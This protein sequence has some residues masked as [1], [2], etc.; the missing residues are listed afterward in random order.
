MANERMTAAEIASADRAG[1]TR[2][3]CA[4][5]SLANLLTAASWVVK[6]FGTDDPVGQTE[7]REEIGKLRIALRAYRFDTRGEL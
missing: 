3:S 7:L 6:L 2:R 4:E 1:Q 5:Q